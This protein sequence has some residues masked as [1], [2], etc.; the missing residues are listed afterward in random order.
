MASNNGHRTPKGYRKLA[1][2]LEQRQKLDA[3]LKAVIHELL[4]IAD[5]YS[6]A[7][8]EGY[9]RITH[10]NVDT[11]QE[12]ASACDM[13][14]AR[15]TPRYIAAPLSDWHQKRHVNKPLWLRYWLPAKS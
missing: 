8:T 10:F 15:V 1:S 12:L 3:K 9:G 14:N 2:L 6:T 7:W 4:D 13:E 11:L 5:G